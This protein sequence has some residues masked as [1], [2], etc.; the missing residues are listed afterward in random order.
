M[1]VAAHSSKSVQASGMPDQLERQ[2]RAGV[3]HTGRNAEEVAARPEQWDVARAP[4]MTRLEPHLQRKREDLDTAGT[5]IALYILQRVH[6][7]VRPLFLCAHSGQACEGA[8]A[9]RLSDQARARG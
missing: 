9:R 4:A 3:H 2:G 5:A 8:P 7:G 1:Q 6:Q